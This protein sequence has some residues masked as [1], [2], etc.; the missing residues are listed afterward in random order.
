M[1]DFLKNKTVEENQWS[2]DDLYLLYLGSIHINMSIL[3][4]SYFKNAL[5]YYCFI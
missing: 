2:G 3:T 1:N 4:F 5:R